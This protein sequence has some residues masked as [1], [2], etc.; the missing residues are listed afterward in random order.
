MKP[1]V[2]VESP[3]AG[4]TGRNIMY[5]KRCVLDCLMRGEVPFASHLFFTQMLNDEDAD[6]RKLGIE[7]GLE[8][9]RRA[10]KT[11]VYTDRGISQ[12]MRHGIEDAERNGR[13]VEYR[14]LE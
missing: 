10:D 8:I 7:A 3:F 13:P 5:A 2:I 1:M 6:E 14:S 9:A 12:G 11:V 4:D